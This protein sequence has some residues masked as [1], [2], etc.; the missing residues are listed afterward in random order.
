MWLDSETHD[1]AQASQG[2]ASAAHLRMQPCCAGRCKPLTIEPLF[3][4]LTRGL[5]NRSTPPT[6]ATP[7]A[8]S[9]LQFGGP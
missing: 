8:T 9:H 6:R 7:G 4:R 5:G 1:A 3:S 2:A